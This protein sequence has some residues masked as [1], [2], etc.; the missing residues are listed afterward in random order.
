VAET[1]GAARAGVAFT[2]GTPRGWHRLPVDDP[3]WAGAVAETLAAARGFG[4]S[5][6]QRLRESLERAQQRAARQNRPERVRLVY[7]GHPEQPFVR[8][9][10]FLE[11]YPAHA[12]SAADFAMAMERPV[13]E[14]TV[15]VRD[16]EVA[17]E[18][19]AG[20][21][22]VVVHEVATVRGPQAPDLRPPVL[23]HRFVA[24][25]F[26]PGDLAV[27]L[28]ISTPDLTA[29]ADLPAVG[30]AMADSIRVGDLAGA[31]R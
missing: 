2:I 4:E 30:R 6:T 24:T 13:T 22:A 16:R 1:R 19:L 11:L 10:A 31:G 18:S 9:W 3:T 27:Q 7:L 21:P 5:H 25:I 17:E 20:H 23:Q 14:A 29:F 15:V 26:V 28:Q 8:A 12:Q